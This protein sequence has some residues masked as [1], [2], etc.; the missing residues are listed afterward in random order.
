MKIIYRLL[1]FLLM[2]VFLFACGGAKEGSVE[3]KVVNGQNQPLSGVN[4]IFNPVVLTPDAKQPQTKTGTDGVFKIAGLAPAAEYIIT[5]ETDAWTSKVTRKITAP[6][7]RQPL[8]LESPIIVRFQ[9]L[10]NG[11]IIDSKS[12]MQWLIYTA[13]DIAAENVIDTVKRINEGGFN[14]WRLPTKAEI[15]SLRDPTA[16]TGKEGPQISQEACCVWTAE[17]NSDKIEWDFYI[18]DGSDFW[19]SSKMPAND[20]IIVIRTHGA[21]PVPPAA[22]IVVPAPAPAPAPSPVVVPPPSTAP[23]AAPPATEN[24]PAEL[25]KVIIHFEPNRETIVKEDLDK[26]KEFFTK[27]K[28]ASGSMLI[29]GHS[30]IAGGKAA[31][32]KDSQDL[33]NNTLG[34]LKK[35]GLS[36]KMKVEVKGEGDAKP[37]ADNN[38]PEGKLKNRR[39][40]LSFTPS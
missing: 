10:R 15:L 35:M 14:D 1:I 3:G 16:A 6:S 31:T 12:G 38:T 29:E 33:A 28:D 27:I 8:V 37:V 22:T 25:S 13:A 9:L 36:N 5:L 2:S 4:V 11:T 23:S 30:N 26:L 32:L 20:R 34:M 19:T 18:D 39:V 7:G 21:P 24:K 17:L 40:E